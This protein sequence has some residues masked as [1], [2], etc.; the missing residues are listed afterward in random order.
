MAALTEFENAR[1]LVLEHVGDHRRV[2]REDLLDERRVVV[3]TAMQP[4]A[5]DQL[6][7]HDEG[8]QRAD[9]L[10]DIG[11]DPLPAST[12]VRRGYRR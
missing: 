7:Q 5:D 1:A 11:R 4:L 3:R 9:R 12:G 8:N 2:A 6:P 10:R